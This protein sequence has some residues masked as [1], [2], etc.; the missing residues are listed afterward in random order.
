MTQAEDSKE[1]GQIGTY[2]EKLDAISTIMNTDMGSG[3]LD[4]DMDS[5]IPSDT[6]MP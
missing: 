4:M 3:E 1:P 6:F 5:S 2:C